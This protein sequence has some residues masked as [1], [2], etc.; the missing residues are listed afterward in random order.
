MAKN[1]RKTGL[2]PRD[3]RTNDRSFS[4]SPRSVRSFSSRNASPLT[5]HKRIL[6][7]PPRKKRRY[8][9]GV[10]A[11]MEIRKYQKSC[12]LLL[13]KLPFMRLVKEICAELTGC[14]YYWR[15]QALLALQE[16]TE[17]YL[18]NLFEDSYLCSL[19]AKRVTLMPSDIRL[20]RRIRGRKDL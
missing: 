11:L 16:A 8:R 5:K 10:R 3:I 17:S 4:S 14:F 20:A 18:V 19:H 9:P 7:S 12:D 13:R 15:T 2:S 6:N 1:K